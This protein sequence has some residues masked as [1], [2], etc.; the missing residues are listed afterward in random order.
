LDEIEGKTDFATSVM[1]FP[2]FII[3][4]PEEFF[5]QEI[6]QD[7]FWNK[8]WLSYQDDERYGNLIVERPIMR[9]TPNGDFATCPVLIG[10]SINYFIESQILNYT[11]RS[12]KINLPPVV[13]KNAIS[14]PFEERVINGLR[15]IG[16][17]A[18]HVNDKGIWITQEGEINLNWSKDE[19]LYGEIDTLAYNSKLNFGILV[20]CKVLNDVRDYKSYKNIIAKLVGDSEGFQYKILNKSTWIN[21]ALSVYYNVNVSVV[22]VILTDIPIPVIN[23]LNEDIIFEYYEKFTFEIKEILKQF[24]DM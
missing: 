23:F 8:E 3:E 12:P 21:Q 14:A 9:I 13:F 24:M 22:C 2:E 1:M 11:S 10:D 6:V 16:F 17:R 5:T 19:R 4:L 20:E 7:T 18:G 15:D